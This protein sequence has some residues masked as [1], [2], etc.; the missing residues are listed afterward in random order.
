MSSTIEQLRARL[1]AAEDEIYR[2]EMGDDYAATNGRLRSATIVRDACRRELAQAEKQE[3]A[4]RLRGRIEI[5]DQFL[6]QAHPDSA[7]AW[8]L[9]Q[10][11]AETGRQLAAIEN[12][13]EVIDVSTVI[14]GVIPTTI[15]AK[16]VKDIGNEWRV[17][18]LREPG[19]G[20]WDWALDQIDMRIARDM[21]ADGAMVCTQRRD[22]DG[23][24]LF[25]KLSKA[26]TE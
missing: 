25:M 24:R 8:R 12:N 22:K 23:T 21:V 15:V 16:K 7:E 10:R 13:E 9:H 17:V 5:L 1:A 4:G 11:L 3:T 6:K 20:T 2:A 19:A 18:A 14:G 26:V